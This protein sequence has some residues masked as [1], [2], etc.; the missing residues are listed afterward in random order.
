MLI[1][2]QNTLAKPDVVSVPAFE[3]QLA[4]FK[5]KLVTYIAASD[6]SLAAQV[7]TT[8]NNEAEIVTKLVEACTVVLQTRIREVNEDAL[9]MFAYWAENSNLDVVVSN[10]GVT[11][12]TIDGG[13]PDAYPPVAATKETDD[14]LRLRYF[15]APHA[16]A[17]G[18]RMHYRH[19]L[20]TLSGRPSVSVSAPEAGQVVVTYQFNDDDTASLVKDGLGRR[21]DP[22]KVECRV[23][24]RAGN[25]TADDTLLTAVKSHFER[26]DVRPETDEVSVY[27]AEIV[28]YE[29]DAVAYVNSGPDSS[30]TESSALKRLNTFTDEHHVLG[31][32]ID[33]S[34]IY[35]ELHE[36]GA[37]RVDIN[38]PEK[39]VVCSWKQ[40]PY[41][42]SV[43]V[44]V[45]TL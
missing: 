11:R 33:L 37:I 28:D 8:L 44:T 20:L 26:E 3:T 32:R 10:L 6:S 31:G 19:E 14:H 23:L 1:P 40:A 18:S 2:G 24:S 29:I 42:T 41:C 12:Q 39:S 45:K 30:L 35:H 25:G 17:A 21:T 9:Q 16:P 22:G 15:L 36:S 38:K 43:N 5:D 27:S 34:W 4:S 13:D 7:E